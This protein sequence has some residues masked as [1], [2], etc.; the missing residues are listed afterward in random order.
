MASK[1]IKKF[2]VPNGFENIL[3]DFAKEILRNQPKDILQ[4]G[5]EYFKGL[6]TNTKID[7]KNKGENRPE[8]YKRPENQKPNIIN[9]PN[10][11]EMSYEDRNRLQRSMDKIERINGEPIPGYEHGGPGFDHGPHGPH[12]GP[13]F[14]YGPHGPHGGPGFEYGP[15]G[16]HGGPGFE[17]G[18]HGGPGF[19]HGPLGPHGIPEF[20]HG[21]HGG[22]G[23]DHGPH[24]GP[25]FDHGPHGPHGGPGFGEEIDIHHRNEYERGRHIAKYEEEEHHERRIMH[26]GEE[27]HRF[28]MTEET[29]TTKPVTVIKNGQV[30]KEESSSHKFIKKMDE[31]GQKLPG[32]GDHPHGRYNDLDEQEK[33]EN[34]QDYGDWFTKHS[35][36][37]Q[38]VDYKPEKEK[39]DEN[40]K[41]TEVG[42]NTWF[43]NHS[44]KSSEN[45]RSDDNIRSE[46][47]NKSGDN[48]KPDENIKSNK[49]GKGGYDDWFTKHSMDKQAIDYKPE[50]EELDENLKR[51]EVGYNT[52]FNNHS[53]RSIDQSQSDEVLNEER[54]KVEY[55]VWF[56]RHSGD[57]MVIE[58][59]PEPKKIEEV[60]RNEVDYQTW[61]Q[62]HSQLTNKVN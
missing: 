49:K 20:D 23:F 58:Y 39:L 15:H 8:N 34:K 36:D 57:R 25:G 35:M 3:S 21:P 33:E 28:E 32:E 52:W 50:K 37:K 5:I 2:K 12:G 19:D 30:V 55:S 56:E 6:E 38:E 40:L 48:I 16:P 1:Y 41:R 26:G 18:P 22:P 13:G 27:G 11:L 62:N 4:F 54:P 9:A 17:Y 53:V 59:K 10:N 45:N 24:G 44:V 42:Y 46:D 51:N 7:Y 14:E 29:H 43:N 61:F 47:N 31:N 60:P